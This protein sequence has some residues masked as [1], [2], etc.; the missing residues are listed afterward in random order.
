MHE[1]ATR[2]PYESAVAAAAHG[3]LEGAVPNP[4]AV[5]ELYADHDIF[6]EVC[7]VIEHLKQAG[8]TTDRRNASQLKQ[9]DAEKAVRIQS[10]F[11]LLKELFN[12]FET[13]D[14]SAPVAVCEECR[15]KLS[16]LPGSF[17]TLLH[18]IGLVEY[19]TN[20][21][22]PSLYSTLIERQVCS[23]QLLLFLVDDYICSFPVSS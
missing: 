16:T 17:N 18:I 12:S 4:N 13:E 8:V 9:M 22:V 1:E 15:R 11:T 5:Q 6:L 21:G 19:L 20:H 14:G 10:L 2:T 23:L 3:L 7:E